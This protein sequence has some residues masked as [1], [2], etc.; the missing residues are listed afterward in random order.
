MLQAIKK[1]HIRFSP[2]S[3][4]SLFCPTPLQVVLWQLSQYSV[5]RGQVTSRAVKLRRRSLSMSLE[6]NKLLI[7]LSIISTD[8]CMSEQVFL[9]VRKLPE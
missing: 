3:L 2:E 9:F 5:T 8:S 4:I 7:T 6:E 1:L